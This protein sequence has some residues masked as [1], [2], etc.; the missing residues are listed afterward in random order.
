MNRGATLA[1][2]PM[3]ASAP[4]NGRREIER[5]AQRRCRL[6]VGLVNTT[7]TYYLKKAA[8]DV[9]DAMSKL[10]SN[11]PD[12]RSLTET[13]GTLNER[14]TPSRT[15]FSNSCLCC[16]MIGIAGFLAERGG[17]EPPIQLLTV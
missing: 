9:P 1:S 13:F 2:P 8:H 12:L 5:Q 17:F 10:E 7:A 14:T 4:T 11:I 6:G 15:R 16:Y 3:Q